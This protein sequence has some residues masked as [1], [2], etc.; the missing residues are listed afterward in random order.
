MT[1]GKAAPHLVKVRHLSDGA[2]G[3]V[4]GM[5]PDTGMLLVL[6]EDGPELVNPSDVQPLG[7]KAAA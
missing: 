7:R 3:I 2:V 4:Q 6:F 1:A 5:D